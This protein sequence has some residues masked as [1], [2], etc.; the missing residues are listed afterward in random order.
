M[1]RPTKILRNPTN[2]VFEPNLSM[3][4]AFAT[5]QKT[6]VRDAL[7]FSISVANDVRFV[8][9]R[10]VMENDLI[11][12]YWFQRDLSIIDI[13]FVYPIDIIK[14][15]PVWKTYY[16]WYRLLISALQ[17][18]CCD[19]WNN[20]DEGPFG[21]KML[22]TLNNND[23]FKTEFVDFFRKNYTLENLINFGEK[24]IFLFLNEHYKNFDRRTIDEYNNIFYMLISALKSKLNPSTMNTEENSNLLKGYANK[25]FIYHKDIQYLDCPPRIYEKI[26]ETK[27]GKLLVSSCLACGFD[28]N[29]L[30]REKINP[31][32]VFC[33]I[34]CQ[35]D[36]YVSQ[37]IK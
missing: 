31:K 22:N 33:D 27:E 2:K 20:Q 14:T 35:K 28:G 18:A 16:L 34:N 4:T 37:K 9:I 24:R 23:T 25:N 13:N 17:F 8:N 30:Q 3:D 15:K 26:C 5:L 36:F 11:W 21:F 19:E 32:H 7:T 10:R 1:E 12:Q 29:E 6:E